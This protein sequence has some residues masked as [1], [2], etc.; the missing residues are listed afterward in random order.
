MKRKLL[1]T[2]CIIVALVISGFLWS[3]I[4][5]Y[6]NTA[7]YN[8]DTGKGHYSQ[9][10]FFF[11]PINGEGDGKYVLSS[12]GVSYSPKKSITLSLDSKEVTVDYYIYNN[13][14]FPVGEGYELFYAAN[15]QNQF[16]LLFEGKKYLADLSIKNAVPLFSNSALYDNFAEDIQGLSSDGS[17]CA[18][19]EGN[20][21][22]VIKLKKD[23][24][25]PEDVKEYPIEG[26]NNPRFVRF[27]NGLHIWFE[28]EKEGIKQNFILDCSTGKINQCEKIPDGF[29]G[30]LQ[31][32]I[33]LFNS[34]EEKD[35]KV[36]LSAFNLISGATQKISLDSSVY[37]A[38]KLEGIAQGGQYAIFS[39]Q[40]EQTR[41]W[42]LVKFENNAVT[43]IDEE[44]S[45]IEFASDQV[46]LI[47]KPDNTH[48]FVKIVH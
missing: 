39:Y 33:W 35:K 32:R 27:L 12:G 26:I 47:N 25:S 45:N 13:A 11:T 10:E 40:K 48:I 46:F 41:S 36:E 29:S 21:A 15:T 17:Y 19:I 38:A 34:P 44:I 8:L 6:E 1:G 16:I 4:K 7:F 2:L 3:L 37:P 42:A 20:S 28:G 14:V 22:T 31:S 23:S 24:L 30:E 18:K 9:N 43:L 5:G